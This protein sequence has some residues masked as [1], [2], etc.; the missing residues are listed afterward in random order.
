MLG[1]QHSPH[2]EDYRKLLMS[3]LTTPEKLRD[4][5]GQSLGDDPWF[6]GEFNWR[7]HGF[8]HLPL[9]SGIRGIPIPVGVFRAHACGMKIMAKMVT[10]DKLS[11]WMEKHNKTCAENFMDLCLYPPVKECPTMVK[12]FSGDRLHISKYEAVLM[13]IHFC[14]DSHHRCLVRNVALEKARGGWWQ[15]DDT[16]KDQ[17]M[18]VSDTLPP[19]SFLEEEDNKGYLVSSYYVRIHM[20][21]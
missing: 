4:L 5:Q 12:W 13:G 2:F 18:H 3:P 15:Y 8:N 14:N 17:F 1:W 11:E 9:P 20:N 10:P 21:A 7:I 16:A 19:E 6:K